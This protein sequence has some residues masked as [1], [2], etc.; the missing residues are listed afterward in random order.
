MRAAVSRRYGSPSVVRLGKVRKPI[1][2]PNEL[3]VRVRVATVNRTDSGYRGGHPFFARVAT[4]LR[5]PKATVLGCEFAGVVEQ[6][7]SRVGDFSVGDRVFGYSEP[8]FGAHAEY[9]TVAQ[10]GPVATIPNALS[11]DLAAA[12]T[13]ASHYA[14]SI[15]RK[16]GIQPG[17]DVLVYG[18]SGGIGT[19]AVQLLKANGVRVTAVCDHDA[20]SVVRRI[21]A[22]RVIDRSQQDFTRDEGRYDF[23]IDAV[24]KSSFA[25]CR[26]LLRPKG[27]YLTTDLGPKGQNPILQLA[28]KLLPGKKVALPLPLSFDK[29]L[30]L[31]IRD[32]LQSGEFEPVI[33]PHTFTLDQIVDAYEYVDSE[34]KIGNVLVTLDSA[35]S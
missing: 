15:I 29:K 20:V 12:S 26:P 1:P 5:R 13:E 23:V 18:A 11:D 35:P 27:S 3:L 30:L 28:T 21:G 8:G 31:E 14:L 10:E 25:Q 6:V 34:Q 22:D 24:G 16:G 2:G 33:D 7:G 17:D 9:L 4:G 19:A 32:L